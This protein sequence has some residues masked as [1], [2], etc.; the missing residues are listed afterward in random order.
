MR[1]RRRAAELL[2]VAIVA[3]ACA[4]T[5]ATSSTLTFSSLSASAPP[6][7]G[8][9]FKPDG[10][11][12]Y[13]AVVLLHG[14]GGLFSASTGQMQ[15]RDADWA[16]RLVRAGYV[17]LMVDSFSPRGIK[18]MCSPRSYRQSVYLD[19]PKDAYGALRWL[20]AQPFV[21]PDRV[22]VMGWSQGGGVTLL[23]VRAQSLG[24]PEHLPLGDFRAAVAFYPATCRE[25]AHRVPW[26]S[27]IPVLV[28]VG[29][30]DN[31]TPAGPCKELV[32]KSA[33]RGSDITMQLYPGAYHDFD[34]PNLPVKTLSAYRT[35]SGVVPVTGMDPAA[36]E[37]A[38]TRVPQ[39]LMKHLGE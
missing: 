17:V 12:R 31:W 26:T 5:R 16:Q 34:W 9:L 14:C 23:S 35:S 11:G 6:I 30:Q 37:D 38:L 1:W 10:D 3:Q 39:F 33:A 25:S 18:E 2:L 15:A 19:R 8:Y 21:K 4:A 24:R 29:D 22:A 13:P 20:Q 36:R 27:A 7:D 32:E 28:L